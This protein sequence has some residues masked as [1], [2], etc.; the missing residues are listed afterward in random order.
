M[1]KQKTARSLHCGADVRFRKPSQR[2]KTSTRSSNCALIC[3]KNQA[4]SDPL[5]RPDARVAI[6]AVTQQKFANHQP[7]ARTHETFS[8][9]HIFTNAYARSIVTLSPL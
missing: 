5:D 2:I 9:R 3:F 6:C 1:Q 7:Q 8:G 4:L